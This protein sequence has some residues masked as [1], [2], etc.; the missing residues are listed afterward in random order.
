[1]FMEK[2][3]KVTYNAPVILSFV[4]LCFGATVAGVITHNHSTELIFSVYRGP[5]SN[6]LT[7]IRLFTHVLGHSGFEHFIGNA[8]YLLLVGPMLEEKY[9]SA[10]MLKMIL[11]TAFVNAIIHCLL[12]GNCMLCGASGIV[13]ACIVLS[14]FTAFKEGE[15]PV[16][17][18]L[19]TMLFIGQE[20]CRGIFMKDDISNITHILGG[21]IGSIMGYSLNKKGN[22]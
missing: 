8:T 12:W 6:P 20:V 3:L 4:L 5:V 22:P 11:C 19:I 2:K 14:S 9:G 15:L 17:F 13:F 7:Y 18:I 21:F 10:N 16:S 1:M